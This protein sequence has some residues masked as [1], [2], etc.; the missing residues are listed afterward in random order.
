M[1][2]V[3]LQIKAQTAYEYNYDEHGPNAV[4]TVQAMQVMATLAVAEQLEQIATTLS[5]NSFGAFAAAEIMLQ[6][7]ARVCGIEEI[8]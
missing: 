2:I 4:E 5:Q 6:P 1:K 7:G 8:R 3:T